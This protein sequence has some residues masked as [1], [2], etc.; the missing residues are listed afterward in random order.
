MAIPI[1]PT[2]ILR[3]VDQSVEGMELTKFYKTYEQRAVRRE[4]SKRS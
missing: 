1:I 4:R 2:F 3:P